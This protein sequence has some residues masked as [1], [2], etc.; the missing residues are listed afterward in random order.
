MRINHAG[1]VAM[2]TIVCCLAGIWLGLNFG[3]A[4]LMPLLA[5]GGLC[6][7]FCSAGSL[8][9]QEILV[10]FGIPMVAVQCGYMIGLTCRD[11][12]SQFR[13]WIFATQ[14]R[15]SV[16]GCTDAVRVPKPSLPDNR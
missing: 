9:F 15:T 16:T 1:A 8:S 12:V 6:I 7:V 4:V 2:M 14:S 11:I 3:V 13:N 5:I 10:L